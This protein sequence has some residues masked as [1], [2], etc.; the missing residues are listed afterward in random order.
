MPAIG[1]FASADTIVPDPTNPQ[2]YNRYSYTLN[3][4]LR[5]SNPTGHSCYNPSSGSPCTL[6]DGTGNNVFQPAPPQ[7]T[8]LWIDPENV[9][10]IQLYG[11]TNAAFLG[12]IGDSSYDYSQGFHGGLD[13]LADPGTEVIAGIRGK[14]Y[15]V[16]GGSYRPNYVVIEIAADTYIVLG[17]L[18][19]VKVKVGDVVTSATV[20]G[21]VADRRDVDHLHVEFW[22]GPGDSISPRTI[23]VPYQYMSPEV[24]AQF[25]GLM[26]NMNLDDNRIT[27]H[28]RSDG[29][30]SS[31]Y[32][33]P[34]L[35]YR[36]SNLNKG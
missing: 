2:Q 1:R 23:E 8:K 16:E 7:V 6:S 18:G 32:D 19:D 33:Q 3:N 36:G 4:P 26:A 21:T 34:T 27:F 5:Y 22:T 13:L 20:V 12:E 31:I 17:H 24:K 14:V 11:N 28:N 9:T 10:A 15:W 30:W 29:M 25:L 35:I